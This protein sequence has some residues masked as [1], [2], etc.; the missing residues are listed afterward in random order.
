MHTRTPTLTHNL[1]TPRFPQ[2]LPVSLS[3]TVDGTCIRSGWNPME[4]SKCINSIQTPII[5][6]MFAH[7]RVGWGGLN[8]QTP[9]TEVPYCL[10]VSEDSDQSSLLQAETIRRSGRG[11]QSEAHGVSPN[12]RRIKR[13]KGSKEIIFTKICLPV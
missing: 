12:D 11:H 8:G 3:R 10:S 9:L 5:C 2:S 1:A 4:L 13:I 6:S 7:W